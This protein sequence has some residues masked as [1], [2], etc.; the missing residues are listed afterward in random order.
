MGRSRTSILG[1]NALSSESSLRLYLV[2]KLELW[3]INRA[4][5]FPVDRRKKGAGVGRQSINEEGWKK[6]DVDDM[7][8]REK[9]GKIHLYGSDD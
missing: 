3:R 2:R 7:K 1:V 9:A 5:M 8:K 4:E 6:R